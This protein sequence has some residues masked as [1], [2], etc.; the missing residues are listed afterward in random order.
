M[1]TIISCYYILKNKYPNEEYLKWIRNFSLIT[2]C[3]IIV[4]TN[5][6]SRPIIEPLLEHNKQITIVEKEFEE[7]YMFSYK[8]KWVSN[9]ERNNELNHRSRYNIDWKLNPLWNE[10][11]AFV[12]DAMQ[13][14]PSKKDE[15]YIW[16]DIGYF[17]NERNGLSA[18]QI[19][20]WP[21][22]DKI[23]SLDKTK[24]YYNQVYGFNIE[25]FIKR[26]LDKNVYGLPN[27]PIQ[28]NQMS[29]GGGFFIIH[30]SKFQWWF[31]TFY[32]KV[33]LY[34]RHDYL[35]K[36]DQM[37]ILN[38]VVDQPSHFELVQDRSYVWFAF[39]RFLS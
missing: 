10:K 6:E 20:Q 23:H 19:K 32:S 38:C 22:I 3:N 30:A 37:I 33:Q 17:R 25:P 16:C 18:E 8:D 11:I 15:W 29:I 28:A 34:F 2:K 24:I 21:N 14:F 39:Q 7:F 36:D 27:V 4:Y 1:V 9:H 5:K 35:I 26:I 12:Q 31:D 13:R